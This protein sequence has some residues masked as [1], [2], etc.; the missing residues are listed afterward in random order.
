MNLNNF[1]YFQFTLN[2][3]SSKL[4]QLKTEE[5]THFPQMEAVLYRYSDVQSVTSALLV[6]QLNFALSLL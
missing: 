1:Q 3:F 2:S 6:H 5:A 4:L